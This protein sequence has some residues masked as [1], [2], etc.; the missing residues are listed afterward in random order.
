MSLKIDFIPIKMERKA[1]MP[2]ESIYQ[3]VYSGNSGMMT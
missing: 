3:D 2:D 1:T